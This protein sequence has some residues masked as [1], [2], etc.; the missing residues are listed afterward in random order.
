L[1]EA[2]QQ[3]LRLTKIN[4]IPRS[5]ITKLVRFIYHFRTALTLKSKSQRAYPIK[6]CQPSQQQRYT[7]LCRSKTCLYLLKKKDDRVSSALQA[8]SV[9]FSVL[10]DFSTRICAPSGELGFRQQDVALEYSKPHTRPLYPAIVPY[11][12]CPGSL[13]SSPACANIGAWHHLWPAS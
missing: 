9:I 7:S 12:R 6:P 2:L 1:R 11:P 10:R 3:D 8:L 13:L 5:P 4:K